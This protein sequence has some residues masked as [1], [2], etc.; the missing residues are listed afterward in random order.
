MAKCGHP[1]KEEKEWTPP[2]FLEDLHNPLEFF[3][4]FY[5]DEVIELLRSQTEHN[6]NQ[7][8]HVNFKV[9]S[10]EIKRF[11]GILLLSGY[12]GVARAGWY[13]EQSIDCHHPGVAACMSRNSFYMDNF[14]T[15]I[16][17]LTEIKSL[18]HDATGTIRGNRVENAPLKDPKD[19]EKM[20]RVAS[21]ECG[22][23]PIGK[24]WCDKQKKEIDQPR[25]FINYN[26]Y[27]GGV[28]RLDQNVGCYRI[29]VRLKRWYWQLLMFP[30]NVS[31]NNVYQLY[32]L[33]LLVRIV[34]DRKTKPT[35][36]YSQDKRDME[37]EKIHCA[38][39]EE[40]LISDVEEDADKNIEC[41][42][43][44]KWFHLKCTV[45]RVRNYMEVAK[46]ERKEKKL[47]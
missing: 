30:L 42:I 12:N 24:R 2:S 9:S 33:S 25:C 31:I 5:D 16:P 28:D 34:S 36:L 39:C 35:D 21:T 43:C 46:E 40:E 15:S 11:R 1:Q 14:F 20:K 13:W 3:E 45:H 10:D 44:P 41:D 19:M 6:A 23:Q 18:G 38:G 32:R 29:G 22:V 7:K 8:G 4:L 27:M 37:K 17:L 47:T 26:K